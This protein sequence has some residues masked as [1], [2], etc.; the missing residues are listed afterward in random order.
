MDEQHDLQ[1]VED[2]LRSVTPEDTEREAPPADLWDAI[3]A[4]AGFGATDQPDAEAGDVIDLQ[5][6]RRARRPRILA[7]VAAA[8]AVAILAGVVV[9]R[10]GDDTDVELAAA[11]LAYDPAAF[12]PLGAGAAADVSLIQEDGSFRIR[13]D[14]ADLPETDE[15][16]LELWLIQP[17]ADGNVAD[18]ISLGTIDVADP[19]EFA[20]PSTHDPAEFFVVDIS[21]E[22]RDGDP[23]HSGRSILRGPLA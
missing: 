11:S 2:L 21:V 20:V 3:R 19:G 17:D 18:L 9:S 4:D 22:P 10:T 16:D 14:D 7:I 12:D 1:R 13:I 23:T 5:Q 8:A 6:A 15:G